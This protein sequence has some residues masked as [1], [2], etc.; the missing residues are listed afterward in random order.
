MSEMKTKNKSNEIF[1]DWMEGKISDHDLQSI[2]SEEEYRHFLKLRKSIDVFSELEKPLDPVYEKIKLKL[3]KEKART[4]I[5]QG[6]TKNRN[7]YK[8]LIP[9]AAAL[10]LFFAVDKF[11]S[12]DMITYETAYG[13]KIA[14]DLPDG[15]KV[16]LGPKSKLTYHNSVWK[17]KRDL[18]LYGD[19][20]F[21]VKKGEKFRVKTQNGE[22]NVLGTE[23]EVKS[24]NDL[25]KVVCFEGS[26]QVKTMDMT[27]ILGAGE[28]LIKIDKRIEEFISKKNQPE[29]LK[30]ESVFENMPLRYVM[31]ELE[32]TYKIKFNTQ[33]ININRKFTGAFTHNDL[34]L[35]LASVFK[36]LGIHYKKQGEQIILTEQKK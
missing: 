16:V 27:K 6:K 14:L 19:A 28:G 34:P 12:P 3:E 20:F 35:A 5:S 25:F 17:K 26:V 11:F 33:N 10:L 1:A 32:T 23:F 15:S 7:L 21:K 4:K 30:D 13:E 22:V 8:I 31:D 9:V 24:R 29:W 2:I 36:P 18:S